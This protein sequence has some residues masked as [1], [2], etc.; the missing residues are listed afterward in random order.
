MGG[1]CRRHSLPTSIHRNWSHSET[2]SLFLKQPLGSPS[3]WKTKKDW[4]VGLFKKFYLPRQNNAQGAET[5]SATT[6]TKLSFVRLLCI[7]C[8]F[9]ESSPL[10]LPLLA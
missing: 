2:N 4:T 6:P 9:E 10:I 3:I 8:P 5:K 7:C 1:N